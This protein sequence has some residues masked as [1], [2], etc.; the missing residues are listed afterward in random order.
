MPESIV[1]SRRKV[2][3]LA[4]RLLILV[5]HLRVYSG[6]E[7]AEVREWVDA[8]EWH[9]RNTGTHIVVFLVSIVRSRSED[10]LSIYWLYRRRLR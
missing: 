1:R 4:K 6:I 5:R 10:L 2:G 9:D 7:I 8:L 3:T